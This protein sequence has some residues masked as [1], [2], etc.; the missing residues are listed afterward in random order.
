M[1]ISRAQPAAVR[2]ADADRERVADILRRNAGDGRLSPDEL[3]TRLDK[4]FAAQTIGDLRAL[5]ADLPEGNV[6]P[7]AELVGGIVR[8][9]IAAARI[10][11]W[12]GAAT[13][14]V[15]IVVPVAV[16][17]GIGV[18]PLAGLIAAGVCV[19]LAAGLV[20]RLRRR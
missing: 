14:F 12:I 20:L 1:D 4:A 11:A 7:A 2:A 3:S 6:N 13:L 10:G 5:L 18:S 15:G 16:G 8:T 17:I 19:L 9:G